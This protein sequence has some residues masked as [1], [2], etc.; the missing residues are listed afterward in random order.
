MS[1]STMRLKSKI[2]DYFVYFAESPS[3][4]MDLVE[5][6]NS[7]FIVDEMVWLHHAAGCLSCL[8]D[9]DMILLPV[10]EERKSLSS[11]E[12]L[13]EQ[14]M[15]RSPKKNLNLISIGGGIT[16]DVTGF[17]AST[18]YRGIRWTYVPTTLLAQTDS[19]IGAKTSLN[20]RRYKNLIGT[21]YPPAAVYIHTPFLAT[22]NA[23]DYFSGLG[24][25]V[26]L[27]L[28]GGEDLQTLITALPSLFERDREVLSCS[29]KKALTIKQSYIEEDE[30]DAG[31]RNMLNYGHCFGHA[32]ET[33]TDFAVPHGQA[34]VIGM[35]L[36]NMVAKNRN[37]LSKKTARIYAEKLLAPIIH[38]DLNSL[39]IDDE[40]IIAAMQLDKK[41]IGEG[42]PLVMPTDGNVMVKVDDLTPAEVR[43]VLA[44]FRFSFTP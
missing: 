19:C 43:S 6:P 7:L 22:Q 30:F 25:L 5:L 41:R 24:E 38:V 3:F 33:A 13:Y 1:L 39:R 4:M 18:L 20:F 16:Q 21:F 36:A 40:K 9:T 11:V 15:D 35:L 28:I 27:H 12:D 26:K 37:I 23:V 8:H 17:L 34:V 2:R 44:D 10:N 42:L 29:I 32:I 31:R 14:I